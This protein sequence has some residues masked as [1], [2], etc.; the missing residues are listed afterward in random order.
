VGKIHLFDGDSV[1]NPARLELGDGSPIPCAHD[2]GD[3][4]RSGRALADIFCFAYSLLGSS[5]DT[6][7]LSFAITSPSD[8]VDMRTSCL[9]SDGEGLEVRAASAALTASEAGL[10]LATL[11]GFTGAGKRDGG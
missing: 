3:V 4:H 8:M 9:R 10:T 7:S 2:L 5:L 6:T 1:A 11:S